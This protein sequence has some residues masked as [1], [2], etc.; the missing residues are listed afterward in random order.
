M[1]DSRKETKKAQPTQ[2][3]EKTKAAKSASGKRENFRLRRPAEWQNLLMEKVESLFR[4]RMQHSTGQ[5]GQ[6]HFLKRTRRDIAQLKT[7]IRE[8]ELKAKK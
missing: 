6:T 3:A 8:A 5:L 2:T 1:A 4:Y 7:L